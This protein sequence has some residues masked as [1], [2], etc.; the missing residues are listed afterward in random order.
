[1]SVRII[2]E[3]GVNHNGS[4]ERALAM[5]DAA[6]DCGADAAKIQTFDPAALAT[7]DAGKAA[8]QERNA[9]G[10]ESQRDMLAALRLDRAAHAAIRD[11]C[12]ARGIAFLST[13]FDAASLDLLLDLG[14]G[15][16]KV[17]SG[18]L[19]NGP[20]L[21]AIARSGRKILLSTG[22]ATLAEVEDALAVIGFGLAAAADAPPSRAAFRRAYAA[23]A[24]HEALAAQ[25][26]LL[27]C[28][29]EYPAPAEAINLRAIDTMTAA[30]GLPVGYS[31]HTD[32]IAVAVAAAA[33]G[34]CVIEKHFTLDRNLPGPDHRASLEP[35]GLAAMVEAI[36]EVEAA[37]GNGRK[38]PAACE[39]ANAGVAR[40]SLVAARDIA[41]GQRLAAAD[42][43]AMRP[44]NG[45]SPMDYW[46]L[47]DSLAPEGKS[48]YDR[49]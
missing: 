4:L 32:G 43:A 1:M 19:T 25:V 22:M 3:I 27:H 18:D 16:I 8:Y 13:P 21:L 36:R 14:V 37:L 49:F 15:E 38:A 31:D 5:V 48:R 33:R 42:I 47:L 28:V 30:F 39:A 11:R 44:G 26:T 34:A 9:P 40:K 41:V 2:A 24:T 6:A 12:A 23:P 29:T 7:P 10:A 45:R 35:D 17:S 46:D 20:L